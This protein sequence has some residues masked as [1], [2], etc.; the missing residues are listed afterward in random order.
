MD[1]QISI[2]DKSQLCPNCQFPLDKNAAFCQKC[3]QKN[4]DVRLTVKEFVSQFF[5]NVFNLDSKIFQSFG[6]LFIPGK[7]T[8]AFLNGQ[9]IKYIHPIRLFLVFIIVSIAAFS[10]LKNP[11]SPGNLKKEHIDKYKERKKL[12]NVFELGIDSTK[13]KTDQH[14]VLESLDSLSKI[15]YRNSGRRVDSINLNNVIRVMDDP[16]FYIALDDFGKYS[17]EEILDRYEVKGFFKRLKVR[18]KVKLLEEETN[19]IPFLLGK[20]TWTVFIVLLLLT[21]VFRILYF[22][23]DFL[24]LEH[25][26]FGLHLNSFF[27]IIVSILILIPERYLS[28]AL[29]CGLLS[30]AIYLF[31]AMKRVY[32]QSFII[33]ALKWMLVIVCYFIS[34]IFGIVL[35]VIGSFLLF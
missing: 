31:I 32:A 28:F 16:D 21:I 12:M 24:Y 11:T 26:I 1:D 17:H 20:V 30:M 5:A 3:G 25:L 29:P 27:L 19:F 13:E 9:R 35:T 4:T 34:F 14:S 33:T 18:Q 22:R 8:N 2:Q 6:A 10:F 7:L 15:F 23:S